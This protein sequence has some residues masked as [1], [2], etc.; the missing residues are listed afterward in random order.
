[1]SLVSSLRSL[2]HGPLSGLGPLWTTL[3]GAYRKGLRLFPRSAT[4]AQS[5]GRYGPFLMNAEFAFSDFANWGGGHNRGFEA[6]IEAC[7]GR[8]CVL[9]VGAH[10]GL[11]TLP[12]SRVVAPG[13]CVYAFEP[14]ATNRRFLREHLAL[15]GIENVVVIESLVG[16]ENR[17]A[18]AFFERC[19]ATGMNSVVSMKDHDVYHET[20]RPQI[21]LDDFCRSGGLA[22]EV[23]K[24]D[25]EGAELDALKGSRE[26]LERCRPLLF[27]SVHP[28]HLKQLGQSCEELARLIDEL[29]YDCLDIDGHPV[30]GFRRDEYILAPRSDT[31][32]HA[33]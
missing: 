14:A 13:G 20:H 11:V 16:Q 1:M 27:L 3:G 2:R 30:E 17:D 22:P 25:I 26:T 21:T 7:R 31:L 5:I 15:N 23:I 28:A 6:C 33:G 32:H 9:D 18:V 29:D 19:E 8:R 24:M 4:T 10:I 12:M